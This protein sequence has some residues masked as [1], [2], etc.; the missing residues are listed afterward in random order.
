V[1]AIDPAYCHQCGRELS[2]RE[3]DGRD[4]PYCPDC[5]LALFRNAIPS[6]GAIV[7]DGDRTLLIRRAVPPDEGLWALPG[8]HPEYDE[9][10]VAALVRELREE[11]GLLVDPDDL[12]PFTVI[13]S[14][15][16]DGEGP[17]RH[18]NMITDATSGRDGSPANCCWGPS[19]ARVGSTGGAHYPSTQP[20][21]DPG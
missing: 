10:P 4:R 20:G 19:G 18:Y 2:T 1:V 15:L 7:R 17:D 16:T 6:V 5:E 11:T 21:V 14:V 8:G 3:L 13:H 9:E 12:R